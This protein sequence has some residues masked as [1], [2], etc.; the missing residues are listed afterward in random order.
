MGK[1]LLKAYLRKD[2]PAELSKKFRE[3]YPRSND[4]I[5]HD[6]YHQH[7]PSKYLAGFAPFIHEH[8]NHPYMQ[9]LLQGIFTKFFLLIKNQFPHEVLN[10]L[11][12]TGSV[13][14]AFQEELHSAAEA[15]GMKINHIDPSPMEGL[16][17][18]HS[19]EE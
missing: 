7:F 18:Y 2:M 19:F 15:Q 1:E 9:Q 16:I 4:N 6:I 10:S 13:A 14:G 17:Q 3:K 12:M 5:L 8:K 11:R